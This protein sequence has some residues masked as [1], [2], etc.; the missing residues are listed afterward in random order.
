MTEKLRLSVADGVGTIELHR[1][2]AI[3]AVDLEMIRAIAA[4]LDAWRNDDAVSLVVLRGAGERGFCAGGDVR[5]VYFDV[6]G[7]KPQAALDFFDEEYQLNADIAEYRKPIVSLMR[8]VCMGGGIGL[9]GHARIRLVFSDSRVAM[10]ET[11]IGFTPDVGGSWLLGRAPGRIGERLGLHGESM[12]A[13]DAIAA[14]F[15][16]L[17]ISPEREPELADALVRAAAS[18]DAAALLAELAS[19]PGE[20]S[21]ASKRELID[22]AYAADS[23]AEIVAT[24]EREAPE[25]AAELAALSPM[26]L[27]VTLRSVRAAR[28]STLRESLAR[29]GR[30]VRWLLTQGHDTK[31]GIRA[32]LVDKDKR[33]RWSPATLAELTP[34]D[35]PPEAAW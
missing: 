13:S 27:T 11:R 22:R 7:G 9:A 1:P 30:L 4:A 18:P 3:N 15:A 14:G 32:L 20:P 12:S 31:E 5:Q 2:Q 24:L 16:D 34:A 26:A 17:Y 19:E 29:E 35:L 8:G 10:P 28:G 25:W 33:P 23:V 21:W 6:T